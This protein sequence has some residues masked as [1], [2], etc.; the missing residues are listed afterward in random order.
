[1][2]AS[3][4]RSMPLVYLRQLLARHKLDG[5]RGSMAA[6]ALLMKLVEQHPSWAEPWL[7]LGFMY[8][9]EGADA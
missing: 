2:Q 6:R 4:F 1:M 8:E 7:E 9:D 3:P 5:A